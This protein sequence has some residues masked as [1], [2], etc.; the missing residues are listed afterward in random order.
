LGVQFHEIAAGMAAMSDYGT[1]ASTTAT[2]LRQALSDF[3]NPAKE[4]EDTMR[5]MGF[6]AKMLREIL[7]KHGLLATFQFL[8]E[9]VKKHGYELAKLFPEV[10]GLTGVLTLVGQNLEKNKEIFSETANAAGDTQR[11][12]EEVTN[13]LQFRYN[14]ALVQ[15]NNSMLELGDSVKERVINVLN[16]FTNV[17]KNVTENWKALSEGQQRF[18]INTLLVIAA[19]GP[20]LVALATM[21]SVY[22]K[23]MKTLYYAKKGMELFKIACATNPILALILV[24]SSLAAIYLKVRSNT[25]KAAEAQERLNTANERA[26]MLE[27]YIDYNKIMDQV[28]KLGKLSTDQKALL[29]QKVE[30]NIETLNSRV[31][32]GA[33]KIDKEIKK[34]YSNINV[35]TGKSIFSTEEIANFKKYVDEANASQLKDTKTLNQLL[36]EQKVIRDRIKKSMETGSKITIDGFEYTEDQAEIIKKYQDE[37]TFLNTKLQK[38]GD[39]I[40]YADDATKLYNST[41]DTFL[42]SGISDA[43]P[44][45]KEVVKG[46]DDMKSEMITSLLI[47]DDYDK[48]MTSINIQE[49]LFGKNLDELRLDATNQALENFANAGIQSSAAIEMLQQQIETLNASI[50]NAALDEELKWIALQENLLGKEFDSTSALIQVQM[51]LIQELSKDYEKNAV[52]IAE[53]TAKLKLLGEQ[54]LEEQQKAK[55]QQI[56]HQQVAD[57]MTQMFTLIGEGMVDAEKASIAMVDTMINGI[58]QIIQALLMQAIIGMLAN[59]STK[60]IP[61]L[62]IATIGIAALKAIWEKQKSATENTAK[63][64]KGGVIPAGYNNDTYPAMLSSGETVLPAKSLDSIINQ[65]SSIYID[66]NWELRG[67]VLYFAMKRAS[68]KMGSRGMKVTN[69]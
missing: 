12:F 42:R 35:E 54:Q 14:Q 24:A 41:F 2:N 1:A 16:G 64:A 23:L 27:P 17:L 20:L 40:S 9:T 5:S 55:N 53:A 13:T 50:S 59:G 61:G 45:M 19:T 29:L 34:S 26:S 66:G 63:L 52:V 21:I 30:Q 39:T 38:T 28:T 60:G 56:I 4:S 47:M 15:V 48:I 3:L 8:N 69:I 37:L 31:L 67:D 25:I 6:N 58:Q 49:K 33:E 22:T 44:I 43:S 32:D 62:V 36:D 18:R 51:G 7:D 68:K 46:M 57:S 65:S 11:A 10:R